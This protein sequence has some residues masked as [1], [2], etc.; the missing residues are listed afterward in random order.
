MKVYTDKTVVILDDSSKVGFGGG[1]QITLY[2]AGTLRDLGVNLI[3]ADYTNKS[4]FAARLS[5]EFPNS[6]F[7]AMKSRLLRSP[8]IPSIL[9]RIFEVI[10]LKLYFRSNLAKLTKA[11]PI[12]K[13]DLVVYVSTKKGLTLAYKLHKTY[14]IAY[15]FHAHLVER[16]N[17][18]QFKG[19]IPYLKEACQIICASRAVMHSYAELPNTIMQ[20]NPS[21]KKESQKPVRTTNKGS[22]FIVAYIGSL[23]PIKGVEYFISAAKSVDNKHIEF[24]IYGDGPLISKLVP[25]ADGRVRFMGFC[26]DIKKQLHEKIDL[27]VLPTVIAEALPTVIIEAKSAGIPVITTNLGGQAEIVRDGVDGML[28]EPRNSK[29]IAEAVKLLADDTELYNTMASA[30][31]ASTSLFSV[32]KFNQTIMEALFQ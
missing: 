3:F 30:S 23:I 19:M 11:L 29:Q 27:L 1:Q 9:R 31:K 6:A 2:V 17:S 7:V 8:H 20:Y 32:D 26:D 25:S 4:R 14:G 13:R 16:P 24:W 5:D 28:V 18:L 15:V 22:Q 12:D 21:Y 10:T